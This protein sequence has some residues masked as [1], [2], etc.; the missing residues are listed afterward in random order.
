M[1]QLESPS[2]WQSA[3]VLTVGVLCISTSAIFVRLALNADVETGVGLS[4]VLSASRLCFASA[5]LA[6]AWKDIYQSPP[7][8]SALVYSAI[9]G[10]F[11][12]AHFASWI[13]SLSFTS[14]AASTTLVT[15]N[16]IWVA[17]ISWLWLG[18]TLSRRTLASIVITIFGS[19]IVSLVGASTTTVGQNP[20]LGNS[21]ALVGSWTFSLYFLLGRAAQRRHLSLPQHAAIAYTVAALTLI[22]MPLLT[23]QTYRDY[24]LEIYGY[25]ALM[26]LIPQLIGHT[27]LNWAVNHM[28]PTLVTLVIL[29]EPIGASVLGYLAFREVPG[30]NVLIGAIVIITGVAVA[31]LGRMKKSTDVS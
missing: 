15:T 25:A 24:P 23:S 7:Q 28:S 3:I 27:S 31:S 16:P 9:A 6:P 11:L 10:F 5:L 21:L 1:K 12:A 20:L 22:P 19:L 8:R 14:I 26:A 13:T 17:L 29:L 18:D 30:L 2:P 4:L